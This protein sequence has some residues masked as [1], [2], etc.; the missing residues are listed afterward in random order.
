[1]ASLNPEAPE[2]FPTKQHKLDPICC[3]NFPSSIFTPHT[4][5]PFYYPTS[6]PPPPPSLYVPF[7]SN[8]QRSSPEP[9]TNTNT[10]AAQEV[11]Q[12]KVAVAKG[13]PNVSKEAVHNRV[14]KA[15]ISCGRVDG[16][17]WGKVGEVSRHNGHVRNHEFR[18]HVDQHYLRALPKKKQHYPLVPMRD[19]A[20]QTTVMIR[21]I[22]S[23][24]SYVAF[25]S[26]FDT[27]SNSFLS[28]SMAFFSS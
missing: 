21:N 27:P 11:H 16:R 14:L 2:F 4:Y 25:L 17:R 19:G 23:K 24:Y 22:P 13:R 6:P 3:P 20:D 8:H 12:Q 5:Y 18:R 7:V 1:M 10:V 28:R 26:L 15:W 9:E